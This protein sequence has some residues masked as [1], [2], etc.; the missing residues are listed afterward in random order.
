MEKVFHQGSGPFLKSKNRTSSMMRDVFIAL[1]PIILFTFYKNGIVPY[2]HHKTNSIAIFYPL[3]FLFLTTSTSVVTEFL[4]YRWVKK[5]EIPDCFDLLKESF[6]ALPGLFLG[7]ILP[8]NTPLC[9]AILGAFLAT[10]VGKIIFGGFGNNI[11][12]PALLGR[13]LIV[14][15]YAVVISNHGGYFNAYEMDTIS[16]ATP[17]SNVS[18]SVIGSYKTLVKPYGSLLDFFIGTIPG[19][20]GETSV[21]CCLIGFCYLAFRKVIKISIPILYIATVF[22]M[23]LIIGN[24]NGLGIWY[25][26]F[27]IMSGGLFFGSIFMATDPVTSPT[28]K[29]GQVLYGIFLGILTVVF[30]YLTPYPEGVLTSILTMNLFVFLLDDIGSKVRFKKIYSIF[31]IIPLLLALI[32]PIFIGKNYVKEPSLDS[33]FKIV[34][35][36][37]KNSITTYVVTQKSFGGLIKAEVKIQDNNVISFKVLEQSDSYFY[38]VEEADYI[39]TLKNS[40]NLDEVDT[41]S[42]ATISS[43]SLKKLLQNT[44]KDYEANATNKNEEKKEENSMKKEPIDGGMVYTITKKSF[45]GDMTVRITIYSSVVQKVE[46][47]KQNDSYFKKIEDSNYLDLFHNI[48][49]LD[50]IDTVSGATISSSTIKEAIKEALE[51]YRK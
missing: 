34:S 22:V 33:E 28:T 5:K 37:Q 50:S 30:R 24:I 23:T 16:S 18:S 19:A 3:V 8:L 14:S 11:F 45:G 44:I 47:L 21:L 25:P 35:K 46:V 39:D 26:L 12:N 10:F 43:S 7:L 32:I 17:L 38:K 6:S 48:T 31:I 41:I 15:T 40:N 49:D 4:Y 27:Q 36:E 1:L 2:I 20:I 42:G 9:L 13:F 29:F 51:D